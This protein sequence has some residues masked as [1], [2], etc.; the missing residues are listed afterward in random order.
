MRFPHTLWL[1]L[2]SRSVYAARR[3][4]GWRPTRRPAAQPGVAAGRRRGP[5]PQP[6]VETETA[7]NVGT[8]AADGAP[9]VSGSS[10]VPDFD[11]REQWY[12][13]AFVEVNA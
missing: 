4:P 8:E 9:E 10:A 6:A 1:T 2:P 3:E 11:W 5:R 12:P 7:V 13:I